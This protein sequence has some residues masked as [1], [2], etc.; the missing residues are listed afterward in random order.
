MR[1][2]SNESSERLGL[3][4]DSSNSEREQNGCKR[5]DLRN[6]GSP[7]EDSFR[8]SGNEAKYRKQS[9][10][11]GSLERMGSRPR[12][13]PNRVALEPGCST[14]GG[15]TVAKRPS[16]KHTAVRP[17]VSAVGLRRW[18][19]RLRGVQTPF[20]GANWEPFAD[21]FDAARELVSF[22]EDRR[23]LYMPIDREY[24]EHCV[25]S[26]LAIREFCTGM[27]ARISDTSALHPPVRLIRG[28]CRQFCDDASA[29]LAAG[30][31]LCGGLPLR[32]LYVDPE[33]GQRTVIEEY[34]N[35]NVPD[36]DEA[37]A[38]LRQEVGAQ[39]QAVVRDFDLGTEW[40]LATIFPE[41]R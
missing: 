15:P 10:R 34:D 31:N 23:V 13:S 8:H 36:F 26:V 3:V 16:V 30:G 27:L 4:A 22:L 37:L 19:K 6:I 32:K 14:V 39:A 11:R 5:E 18:A 35:S 1:P 25:Q 33:T 7:R 24:P 9:A 41:R 12:S 40:Q 20:G 2:S 21:D 17:R 38:R 29:F 28:A